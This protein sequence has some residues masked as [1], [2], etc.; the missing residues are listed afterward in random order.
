MMIEFKNMFFGKADLFI[1]IHKYGPIREQSA[2]IGK[3][4]ERKRKYFFESIFNQ[5]NNIEFQL[6][7]LRPDLSTWLTCYTDA[8]WV[9]RSVGWLNS[10]GRLD[11]IVSFDYLS[12]TFL[13]GRGR[14]SK[15]AN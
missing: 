11:I 14:P 4:K 9:D 13:V 3:M 10:L 15:G 1:L 5:S 2:E 12:G 7:T 6:E 8:D